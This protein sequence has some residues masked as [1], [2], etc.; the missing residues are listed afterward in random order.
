MPKLPEMTAYYNQAMDL[1]LEV[2]VGWTGKVLA[3]LS[4]RIFS[5][6]EPEFDNYRATLSVEKVN[7][8]EDSDGKD[9]SFGSDVLDGLIAQ[10]QADLKRDMAGFQSQREK[11]YTSQDGLPAYSLWFTWH[12]PAT[13]QVHSQIQ[14]FVLTANGYLYLFNA[15]TLKPL[16]SRHIPIFDHVIQTAHISK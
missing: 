6:P 14:A 10:A 11:K 7:L 9:T 15:A 3:P 1:T 4:F 16:E 2:P 8:N 13:G 12:D 5:Q